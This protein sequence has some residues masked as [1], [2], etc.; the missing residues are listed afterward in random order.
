VQAVTAKPITVVDWIPYDAAEAKPDHCGG[1]GG[2]FSKGHRWPD[3]LD[4]FSQETQPFLEAIRSSV[5]A[6]ELKL[7]GE[8]HQNG[9]NG[10][11]LFSDG[12]VG[13]FSYRAWGDLMA[14]IWSTAL[15][16]DMDYM[17]FYM[18]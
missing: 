8:D 17:Q 2:W 4:K 18:P 12:S 7:T 15:D 10:V 5:L 11:P 3:Y 14:A 16:K 6:R 13:C 9:E 1:L